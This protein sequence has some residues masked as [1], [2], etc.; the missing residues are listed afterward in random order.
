MFTIKYHL[1][2]KGQEHIRNSIILLEDKS[3]QLY[4]EN[5][6]TD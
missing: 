5:M 1:K 2:R 4:K 6:K 3:K